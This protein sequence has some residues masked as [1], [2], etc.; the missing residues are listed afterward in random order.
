[1]AHAQVTLLLDSSFTV[2]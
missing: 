2:V 1:M